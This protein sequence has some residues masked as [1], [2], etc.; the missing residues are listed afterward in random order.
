MAAVRVLVVC[1]GN[2]CRSPIAAAL[3][4]RR[5]AAGGVTAD[6]RSAGTLGWGERPAT[7]HAVAVAAERGLDISNHISRRLD[8]GPLAVELVVAMTRDHAGAVIA[9]DRSLAPR[10]FLPAEFARLASKEPARAEQ[11]AIH[12]YVLRIGG[13]RPSG[14]VGRAAEQID[15]PAGEPLETYRSVARRLDRDLSAFVSAL[16]APR[17]RP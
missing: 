6:V 17:L 16:V 10:T 9:R 12:D 11:E 13:A 1:T 5:L 4:E 15:D 3:L 2:T 7:P 8:P 14:P